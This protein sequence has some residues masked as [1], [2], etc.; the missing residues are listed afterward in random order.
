MLVGRAIRIILAMAC[1]IGINLGSNAD[2]QAKDCFGKFRRS[3]IRGGYSGSL[4]CSK[5]KIDIRESG[6]I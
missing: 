5:L 3:L 6:T 1:A 2:A 4:D